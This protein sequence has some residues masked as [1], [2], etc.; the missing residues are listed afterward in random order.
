MSGEKEKVE[1]LEKVMNTPM[2]L[3]GVVFIFLGWLAFE[4][5]SDAK[6]ERERSETER[7]RQEHRMDKVADKT[8]EAL[9]NN[10][11]ALQEQ[12]G[13]ITELKILIETKN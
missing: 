4:V 6:E 12:Q 9:D 7:I 2:I 1:A 5:R 8:V 11:K 3:I 10:T 13:V